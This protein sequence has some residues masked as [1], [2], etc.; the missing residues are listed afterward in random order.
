MPQPPRE[1]SADLQSELESALLR[2][3]M[4]SPDARRAARAHLSAY[5]RVLAGFE[6]LTEGDDERA[7]KLLTKAAHDLMDRP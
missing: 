4:T 6:A 3:G 1:A 5:T 7:L 2:I